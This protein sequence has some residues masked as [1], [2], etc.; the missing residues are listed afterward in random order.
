M[1]LVCRSVGHVR[2]TV[3]VKGSQSIGFYVE[4]AELS[5]SVNGDW[6]FDLHRI[7]AEVTNSP[8]QRVNTPVHEIAHALLT[9]TRRI[10]GTQS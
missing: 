7:Q 8:A 2:V 6:T 10:D 1:T 5:V 9:R 3:R 4:D